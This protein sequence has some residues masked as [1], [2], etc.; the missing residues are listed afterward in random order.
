MV[1]DAFIEFF[2]F[3]S[4]PMPNDPS[5]KKLQREAIFAVMSDQVKQN[6][7]KS[8]KILLSPKPV[9]PKMDIKINE[10]ADKVI[11]TRKV[12]WAIFISFL[13]D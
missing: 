13:S 11:S 5:T 6:L 10:L 9:V 12:K 8:L 3:S 2:R 1:F 7:E 4:Y